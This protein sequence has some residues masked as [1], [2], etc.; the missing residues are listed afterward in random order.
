M[1]RARA[2][3]GGFELP[4]G[5]SPAE[6]FAAVDVDGLRPYRAGTSGQPHPLAG[7]G[8]RG[9]ADRAPAAGRRRHRPL[10]VLDA[11]G[12]SAPPELLDAAVR[13][14]A[15]LTL[16]LARAG[17]LRAAAA[18]RAARRRRST[19][20][21]SPGR[22][23]TR[24]WRWSR[25]ARCARAPAAGTGRG[26]LGAMIY[27][28]AAPGGA[29]DR[30][31]G[32]AGRG[33]IVLVVPAAALG[34]RPT[35]RRAGPMPPTLDVSG[36]RGFV[37][38]ARREVERVKARR[39]GRRE[40]DRAVAER[41]RRASSARPRP[42]RATLSDTPRSVIRLVDASPRWRCTASVRW[43]T[44]LSPRPDLASARAAG[45]GG[46]AGRRRRAPSCAATAR[47][48]GASSTGACVP[49]RRCPL[50]GLR[51][52]SFVHVRIARQ[53]SRYIGD[54][55]VA[56][57]NAL[58][59]YTG[60]SHAVR[61]VIV[62]GA[63]VL[64]LDAAARAGLRAPRLGDARRAGAALPLIALAVVPSTL[65]RPQLPY[66]QGLLLFALLAAFMWGERAAGAR[67]SARRSRWP[68]WRGSWARSLAPRLDPHKPL[69]DYRAWAGSIASGPRGH[70]QL[71]PDLR[72]AALAARGARGVHRRR[73]HRRLLEGREPRR[74]QRHAWV[75]GSNRRAAGAGAQRLASRCA[76]VDPDDPGDDPRDDAPLT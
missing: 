58:V 38:G 34:G 16:E 31:A 56:L 52:H 18:R 20:S 63:A 66:L 43:A 75:L 24:G 55:L 65:V 26:R 36:C 21:S 69:V 74:L 51:W 1:A 8:P 57:P 44:L 29:H 70:V 73:P 28:A 42:T 9:G 37:L 64:L 27:V 22:P 71:E 5:D 10:V 46:R 39:V 11:R 12:S 53:R 25:A 48:P 35:A 15:S 13:A 40:L 61:T 19:A 68:P 54:G 76:R 62:L 41:P 3:A 17:R 6:A 2:A 59:P 50:A 67:R 7:R 30:A 72:A 23:R 49:A 47:V 32:H 45:A 33:A 14:A 60:T 4:D